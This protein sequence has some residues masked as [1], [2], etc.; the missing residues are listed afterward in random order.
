MRPHNKGII[1]RLWIIARR[2]K[3]RV[4]NARSKHLQ[5]QDYGIKVMKV[6]SNQPTGRFSIPRR[7]SGKV[8]R[9][10]SGYVGESVLVSHHGSVYGM[11]INDK[12]RLQRRF[13]TARW[14]H[15]DKL[16]IACNRP[17]PKANLQMQQRRARKC[18]EELQQQKDRKMAEHHDRGAGRWTRSKTA[19]PAEKGKSTAED[20]MQRVYFT[21][22]DDSDEEFDI[23][24]F[25][26]DEELQRGV[27]G[28]AGMGKAQERKS[29]DSEEESEDPVKD[30]E[31][32]VERRGR[33]R[34]ARGRVNQRGRGRPVGRGSRGN[35]NVR[36]E[37][38]EGVA[39]EARGRKRGKKDM[40]RRLQEAEAAYV[41]D[42]NPNIRRMIEQL[43]EEAMQEN[44]DPEM[45]DWEQFLPDP[46]HTRGRMSLYK[47]SL[48]VYWGMK[49]LLAKAM[50][51]VA[52]EMAELIQGIP[53]MKKELKNIQVTLLVQDRK[54]DDI[55]QMLQAGGLGVKI[56]KEPKTDA[57]NQ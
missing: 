15:H 3:D 16:R 27:K 8:P 1:R 37:V 57:P 39:S 6:C 5:V 22:Q 28:K 44:S 14:Q 49:R 51:Q 48:H 20:A 46:G 40:R 13:K 53:T 41:L 4:F 52:L 42:T 50:E 17:K 56:E 29:G 32:E 23:R 12:D 35:R 30:E 33:G 19:T 21:I 54:M 10:S 34:G 31:E 9:R 26:A 55:M 45:E 43:E 24:N 36:S 47:Q 7:K 38:E 25:F 2:G 11:G 18:R